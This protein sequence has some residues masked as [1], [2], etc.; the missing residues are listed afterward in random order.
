[1]EIGNTGDIKELYEAEKV[2][3]TEIGKTMRGRYASS[4]LL[5]PKE[6]VD[7][8]NKYAKE[9]IERCAEVGFVA[10]VE[11]VWQS[12]E[13]DADDIPLRQSPCVSDNADDNN[14]YFIPRLILSARTEVLKEYDHDK[15]KHEVREGLFDGIKG[16]IDPNTGTLRED[17]KKRDIY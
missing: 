9:L 2:A 8:R 13:K 1:M 12:E 15:Q 7:R 10:D 3:L 17:A 6:E 14:L 16:V 4:S 11:W 5:T